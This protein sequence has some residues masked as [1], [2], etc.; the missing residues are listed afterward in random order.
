MNTRSFNFFFFLSFHFLVLFITFASF[1][2]LFYSHISSIQLMKL[3]WKYID[4]KSPLE[5][6]VFKFYLKG[7]FMCL[8]RMI[9]IL[10]VFKRNMYV[11]FFILIRLKLKIPVFVVFL[12]KKEL[13]TH[14]MINVCSK[15]YSKYFSLIVFVANII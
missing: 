7:I 2:I 11:I 5:C 8:L 9:C 4:L 6:S 1:V 14:F 12:I 15:L 10:L 3:N 13:P